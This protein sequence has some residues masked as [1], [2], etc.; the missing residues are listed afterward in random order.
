MFSLLPLPRRF[1][2]G[3]LLALLTVF[4]LSSCCPGPARQA[5]EL[6]P[7][8]SDGC[9]LFP[10]GTL[11]DRSKWCHCCLT[12]DLAYWQGG[13]TKERNLADAALRDCVLKQTGDQQLAKT[14]YLG[15]RVGGHPAFPVWYRWGYGW[16][17]GRG[18]QPLSE[19]ESL[20]V[21][22]QIADYSQQHPEGYCVESNE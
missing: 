9:S 22:K 17:Y 12:H 1:P 5:M 15:T 7:F 20:Q 19:G 4:V 6:A 21:Q 11:S 13:S 14:M 2:G 3:V 16:A 8:T 10:D 18:Y